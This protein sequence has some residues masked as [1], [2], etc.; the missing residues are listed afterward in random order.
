MQT[1][2]S[3]FSDMRFRLMR[4]VISLPP[5]VVQALRVNSPVPKHRAKFQPNL[6]HRPGPTDA[7][8][9]PE[10]Q[11]P[12]TGPEDTRDLTSAAPVSSTSD[13]PE[14]QT[15]FENTSSPTG[16]GFTETKATGKAYAPVLK[17]RVIP[18]DV[19]EVWFSGC[20]SGEN[21]CCFLN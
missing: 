21:F 11:H 19:L 20:H 5:L 18:A 7:S 15:S 16:N 2:V 17:E 13:E 9:E 6:Y 1:G 4:R 3:R 10:N 8:E 14:R 12:N